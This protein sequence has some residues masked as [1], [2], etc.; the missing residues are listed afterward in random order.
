MTHTP[1]LMSLATP[2]LEYFLSLL[3]AD[4]I[5]RREGRIVVHADAGDAIW[6]QRGDRWIT[7]A[8]GFEAAMRNGATATVH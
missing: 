1:A 3:P 2:S 6:F 5:T 7:A 8:P 4:R